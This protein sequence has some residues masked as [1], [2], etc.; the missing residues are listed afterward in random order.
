[1]TAAEV[2]EYFILSAE[3]EN[4]KLTDEQ[5]V[6]TLYSALFNRNPDA[7]G[8]AKWL[9]KLKAGTSRKEVLKGFTSATEFKNLVKSF[10]L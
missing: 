8:K 9:A 3:F 6:T 10:G 1:M 7:T 2:A 5:F 4:R